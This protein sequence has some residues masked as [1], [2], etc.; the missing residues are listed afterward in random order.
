MLV[1]AGIDPRSKEV[2]MSY[3]VAIHDISD[4]ERFWAAANDPSVEFPPGITLHASYP[5]EGG[6]RAVCLWE[7]DSANAVRE[8]IESTTGDA[9]NNEFFE[10]DPTHAG[11]RGLPTTAMT[12]R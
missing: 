3:I 9:S 6:T 5:R 4:P 11:L 10:V 7:A 1:R 8:L 12:A 2:W